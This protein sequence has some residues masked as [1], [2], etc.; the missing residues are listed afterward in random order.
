M[1]G[2]LELN[3]PMTLGCLWG[4]FCTDVVQDLE[5]QVRPYEVVPGQTEAV[6]NESVDYLCEVFRNRPRWR[7]RSGSLLAPHDALLHARAARGAPEV[8][9]DRGRPA[10]READGQDH[11]RVLPADRRGRPELQHPPLAG[12]RGRGGLPGRHRGLARLPDAPGPAELRGLPRHREG[13]AAQARPRSRCARASSAGPTT[14][15]ARALGNMPHEMPDQYE[16]RRLAA[17]YFH[18]PP[19]RRR[20]RHAGR[21][22][23]VGPPEQEGPHD[24]RAVAVRLHAEHDDDRRHGGR[25]RQVPG[26]PLRA[27]R[28]QGRRR[29]ARAVALPDDPD[30]GQEARPARVRGRAGE[31]RPHARRGARLPA[32]AP[33][34]EAR[35]PTGSRTTDAA[36]GTAAKLRART[37][38]QRRSGDERR[39]S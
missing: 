30:R 6:V 1:G 36:A 38:A 17:P 4:I 2:G 37:I 8:L 34:D 12:G 9:G 29:G 23:A 5:Y 33:R 20:G 24:L 3:L 10:A 31:D 15:C 16:L 25:A 26:P 21:Q 28:D 22:G 13:R 19:R 11:R 35:P 18:Q 39:R 14:G 32:R 7:R 27:D